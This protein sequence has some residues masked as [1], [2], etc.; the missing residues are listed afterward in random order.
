M[1][2]RKEG[3]VLSQANRTKLNDLRPA[4]RDILAII[5]DLLAA[6]EPKSTAPDLIGSTA[7]LR[8]LITRNG[9]EIVSA[10]SY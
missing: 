9:G 10:S 1:L 8:A 5:D 4:L 7:T 6:A 2:A 3:R